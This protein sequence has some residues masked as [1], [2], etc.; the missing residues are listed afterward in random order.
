MSALQFLFALVCVYFTLYAFI[1][2]ASFHGHSKVMR[3]C[4]VFFCFEP[5]KE[6]N[7]TFSK[8]ILTMI[9]IGLSLGLLQT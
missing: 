4:L 5:I 3:S 8:L 2:Y 6:F 1:F 7:V 9:H